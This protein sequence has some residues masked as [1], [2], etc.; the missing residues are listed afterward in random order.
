VGESG[1]T[2]TTKK[3]GTKKIPFHWDPSHQKACDA[4]KTTIACDV[5]LDYPDYA[6]LFE[7]YT[8]VSV[9]QLGT[10]ISQRGRGITSFSRKLTTA[11]QKYSVTELELLS[12]VE[13]LKEFQGM[14]WGKKIKVY[15]DHQ[16]LE[17]SALDLTSNRVYCWRLLLKEYGPEIVHTPGYITQ[18]LMQLFS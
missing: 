10:V 11:Q 13:T 15:T 18:W 8:D 3:K 9:Q 17:R 12:I 14:L 2:K 7:I 5:A 6:E 4:I 1:E 16:N